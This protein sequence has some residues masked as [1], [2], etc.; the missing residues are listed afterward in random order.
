MPNAPLTSLGSRFR[1]VRVGVGNVPFSQDNTVNLELPN[2]LLAKTV[3]MRLT[4]NLVIATA[5]AANIFAEAPLGL[6]RR[7]EL[8]CDG[9]RYLLST[10][11]RDLFRLEHV[12]NRKVGELVPPIVTIGTRPFSAL[13][14]FTHEALGFM[15]PSESLFDPRLYKKVELRITWGA[16]SS[17]ATA[18]GGGTIAIDA[19]TK[20]SVSVLQTAEGVD[21]ILFDRTVSFDEKD[22]TATSQGLPFEIPQNG[23]LAGILFRTDRDAGAGAGPVPVD[24]LINNISLKSDTTVAHVDKLPWVDLQSH[25]V[26]DFSL[27]GAAVAGGRIT[28]YAFLDLTDNAMF[29]SALNINALNKATLVLDVTRTSG[30]ERIRVS[31]VFYEPRRGLASEVAA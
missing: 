22:V 31:Y 17:I 26:V 25:N 14:T 2:T 23:L 29:S 10:A 20:V 24:D 3:I 28:G 27:D 1:T 7:V 13:L 8:V 9:R 15:D 21:Q 5:N 16:A 6:I 18:G 11:A 12:G 19:A 4:G 30:T